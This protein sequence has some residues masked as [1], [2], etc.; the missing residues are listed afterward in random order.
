MRLIELFR[1]LKGTYLTEHATAPDARQDRVE[2]TGRAVREAIRA[3][4]LCVVYH[5]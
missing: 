2:A 3:A 4:G 5:Q 1:D